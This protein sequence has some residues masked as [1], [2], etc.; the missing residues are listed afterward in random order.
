MKK[1]II[2]LSVM[3]LASFA[4]AQQMGRVVSV[5]PINQSIAVP[6]QTCNQQY[7]AQPYNNYN[8]GNALIGAIA[9]GVIGDAVGGS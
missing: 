3:C 6:Q 2:M 4:Q 7:I 8:G 1:T 5:T 9:G